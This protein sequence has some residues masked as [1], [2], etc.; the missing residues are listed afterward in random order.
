MG[1]PGAAEA[2]LR[3]END[4]ARAGALFGEMIGA[5]DPGDA[6]PDDH[7]VEVLDLL[8]CGVGEYCHL[9]HRVQ[10]RFVSE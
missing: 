10:S 1:E 7:D 3:F 6:G 5:A 9:G 2:F 8:G 4:K